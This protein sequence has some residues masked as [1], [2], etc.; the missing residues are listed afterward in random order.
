MAV[1]PLMNIRAHWRP[2]GAEN[3]PQ[4]AHPSENPIKILKTNISWFVIML[5]ILCT[6]V[7]LRITLYTLLCINFQCKYEYKIRRIFKEIDPDIKVFLDDSQMFFRIFRG[8]RG[9]GKTHS[10]ERRS[11]EHE[12]DYQA[13]YSPGPAL[14]SLPYHVCSDSSWHASVIWETHK[15]HLYILWPTAEHPFRPLQADFS[16]C[17]QQTFNSWREHMP[18]AGP[19]TPPP[20]DSIR[21]P[22]QRP[23]TALTLTL[24]ASLLAPFLW[25]VVKCRCFS[26]IS[27][28]PSPSD[29]KQSLWGGHC[30]LLARG[31]DYISLSPFGCLVCTKG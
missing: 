1:R 24:P 17:S 20:G 31:R 28:L 11:L 14:F 8:S 21:H 18:S 19:H 22:S 3:N 6:S 25:L 15:T 12:S 10:T 9:L 7:W 2:H 26:S 13:V 23:S 27:C 29:G 16:P 30:H 4:L 5:Y